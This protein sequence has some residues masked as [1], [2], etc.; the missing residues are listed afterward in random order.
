M[1]LF[2]GCHV[3]WMQ[4][5]QMLRLIP[6][7]AVFAA[8]PVQAADRERALYRDRDAAYQLIAGYPVTERYRY[9]VPT[10]AFSQRR[11][12]ETRVHA[13]WRRQP[14]PLSSEH[15]W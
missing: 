14:I 6:C 8:L 12:D 1:E 5:E 3:L 11:S 2:C 10:S 15:A 9:Y 13:K 7:L 4:E